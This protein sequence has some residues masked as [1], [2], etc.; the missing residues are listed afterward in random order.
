M[1]ASGQIDL[2]GKF[3]IFVGQWDEISGFPGYSVSL[4][5][6]VDNSVQLAKKE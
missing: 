4:I 5:P 1:I 2:N 3:D 6:R